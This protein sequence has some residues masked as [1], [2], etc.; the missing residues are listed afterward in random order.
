MLHEAIEATFRERIPAFKHVEPYPE[1][2]KEMGEPALVF[3][4]T[5]MGEVDNTGTGKITLNCR[6]Q[7]VVLVDA[8]RK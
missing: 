2:N 5:G 3:A 4:V 1:L 7:A 6:F 8:T